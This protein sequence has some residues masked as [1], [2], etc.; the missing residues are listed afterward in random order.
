MAWEPTTD[1]ILNLDVRRRADDFRFELCD[2]QFQPIGDIHPDR[3]Q[4]TPTL[5]VD[6]SND[7][8]RR[9]SGLK[10]LPN[11]AAD[12]NVL[13]DRLRVYMVL[14]NGEE[15]RL[16]TFL[17]GDASTAIRSW[18]DEL[19]SEL[20]DFGYIL[21]QKTTRPYG[22]GRGANI[23]LIMFFL[24]FRAGFELADIDVIGLEANRGMAEPMAWDPGSTWTQMLTDLGDLV[25]F[26]KPWFN[27]SGKAHLD[28]P[29]DPAIDNPTVPPYEEDTRIIANSL[30][31]T[32]GLLDAPNDYG[33][34]TSGTDRLTVGRYQVP[35]S[36]PHSF[37]KR[38]FRIGYTENVQGLESTAQANKAA[39]NLA[40]TQDPA[41]EFISFNST[42][43]PRHTTWDVMTVLGQNYLET[44][45]TMELRSGGTH[46]HTGRRTS[47]DP[48]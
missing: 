9:L 19:N 23:T 37:A 29:P 17:W 36:A 1:Q 47:Y 40:R 20:A 39:R 24:L 12:I 48:G 15:F 30:V 16:G 25:G 13:T 32:D 3:S 38:G 22:W 44:A 26:A 28:E 7:S 6:T 45:H 41:F 8:V 10:L 35:A 27:E 46:Q 11:E 34:F 2:Q 43:D 42:L 18:G 31:K 14:Q 5:S 4:S 21:K 33:A